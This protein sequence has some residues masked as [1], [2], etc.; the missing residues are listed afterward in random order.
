MY[1]LP[2]LTFRFFGKFSFTID[3]YSWTIKVN[4]DIE[5]SI[6]IV[7]PKNVRLFI[8]IITDV[9]STIYEKQVKKGQRTEQ[10]NSESTF[11]H[12]T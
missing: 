11:C 10:R 5:L 7:H 8:M 4:V 12:P 2:F 3:T 9:V 1:I 6:K